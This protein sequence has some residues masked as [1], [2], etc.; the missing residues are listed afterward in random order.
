V[1]VN[2]TGLLL[3]MLGAT[4]TANGPEVAP[5]GIVMLIDVALHELMLTGM[6]FNITPPVALRCCKPGT[7]YHHLTP[8]RSRRC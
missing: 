5:A 7:R 8:D 6:P 3:F 2:V 4:N 1:T